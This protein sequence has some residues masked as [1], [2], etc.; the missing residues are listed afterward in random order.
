MSDCLGAK[1][2]SVICACSGCKRLKYG[3][4]ANIRARHDKGIASFN[5][6]HGDFFREIHVL[7]GVQ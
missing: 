4:S 3:L 6:R 7:D 5:L 2:T 1:G